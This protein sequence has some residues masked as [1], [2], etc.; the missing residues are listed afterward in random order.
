MGKS[1]SNKLQSPFTQNQIDIYILII[2]SN[3]L[4][5]Y[6]TRDD[7]IYVIKY[8]RFTFLHYWIKSYK[9]QIIIDYRLSHSIDHI[10]IPHS[11]H[12]GISSSP[13]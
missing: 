12:Q 8:N 6:A 2:S 1:I 13:I 4:F 9:T 7:I 11:T 3:V 5:S 10:D